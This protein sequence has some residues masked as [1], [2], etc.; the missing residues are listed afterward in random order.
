MGSLRTSY[1]ITI[2]KKGS[3]FCSLHLDWNYKDGWFDISMQQYVI[4]TLTKLE[5]PPP[6][7]PRHAPHR[8]IP[9]IYGQH[10]HLAPKEDTSQILG[11]QVTKHVQH[12][13]GSFLYYA[14]AID[15]TIRPV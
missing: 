12:I 6:I 8:W 1:S 9:K 13:L 2:D 11:T 5:H 15:N 10:V 3:D 4:K 14:R 7:K